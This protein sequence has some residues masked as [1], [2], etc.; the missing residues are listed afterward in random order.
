MTGIDPAASMSALAL[1]VFACAAG[2]VCLMRAPGRLGL[3][4]G[5]CGAVIGVVSFG[6]GD[7]QAGWGG[8]I[9]L[10]PILTVLWMAASAHFGRNP[11]SQSAPRPLWRWLSWFVAG[12]LGLVL[13]VAGFDHPALGAA[14]ASNAHLAHVVPAIAMAGLA[15][16][17]GL[18]VWSLLGGHDRAP[19]AAGRERRS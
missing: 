5:V 1:L 11:P 17:A 6:F 4:V 19:A 16:V 13:C 8:L 18:G 2:C 10:G 3:G 7:D 14:R 12:M 9:L 15:L